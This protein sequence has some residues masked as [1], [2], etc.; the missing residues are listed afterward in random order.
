MGKYAKAFLKLVPG[1]TF[2][3][4]GDPEVYESYVW[5]GPGNQPSKAECDAIL[6]ELETEEMLNQVKRQRQAAYQAEADPLYFGWQRGENT[7]QAWLDKVAEIRARY[8]YP[9]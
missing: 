5:A 6:V 9:A 1:C 8:P 3:Y 2:S 7:E 4:T